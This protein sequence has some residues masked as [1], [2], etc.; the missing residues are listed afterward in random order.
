M[1]LPIDLILAIEILF[2][3]HNDLIYNITKCICIRNRIHNEINIIMI[4]TS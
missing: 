4:E 3:R 2:N 1:F